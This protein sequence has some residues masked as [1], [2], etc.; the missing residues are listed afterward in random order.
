MSTRERRK[1]GLW[2]V[3]PAYNEA[4]AIGAVLSGLHAYLPRVVVVDDGSSDRTGEIALESGAAVVRH[5]INLGQGAALQTGI[6]YALERNAAYVCTFDADGQ[7]DPDSIA[8]LYAALTSSG[9]DVA[10]GSRFLGS[11]PQ[12]PVLR[13]STLR[14]AVAL[15]RLQTGLHLTDAH[16]GLRLLT[17]AA[18]ERIRIRQPGMAHASELLVAIAHERLP[19]VEVPTR[20]NYTAYSIAKGQSVTNSVK[21]LFDLVYAAWTR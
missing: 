18:A 17:R 2:I 3:V 12:M 11:A 9:A 14:A 15:T 6:D 10:L 13:R 21:I 7:H 16:N 1:P 20:V 19:Y 8:A 5:A 4:G